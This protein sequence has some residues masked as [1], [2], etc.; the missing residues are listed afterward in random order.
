MSISTDYQAR[1]DQPVRLIEHGENWSGSSRGDHGNAD[2]RNKQRQS[3]TYR[4]CCVAKGSDTQFGLV[5]NWSE[6]GAMVETVLALSE[7][8]MISY[9]WDGSPRIDARVAWVS[10]GRAG[11]D[12]VEAVAIS[13]PEYPR[14]T[15]RI[16]SQG[17]CTV[18]DKG[19]RIE[20]R[21]ANVSLVGAQVDDMPPLP[22]GSLVSLKI[23]HM[24]IGSCTVRW[25]R[26]GSAGLAFSCAL[27]KEALAELL[28]R[29]AQSGP[30]EMA[31]RA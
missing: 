28:G 7:G 5:R 3:L 15:V 22:V 1:D 11:L 10:G 14:R 9:F 31:H 13:E 8:D 24:L 6:K 30:I 20:C 16:P 2:R 23:G 4:P 21:L 29:A 12:H 25:S 19:R 17:R 18:W 27:R 26:E